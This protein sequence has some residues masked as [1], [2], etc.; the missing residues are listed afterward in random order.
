MADEDR[1]AEVEK[2]DSFHSTDSGLHTLEELNGA[3]E[4]G[5]LDLEPRNAEQE[6]GESEDDGPDL[7][8]LMVDKG[9]C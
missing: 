4:H 2:E 6:D 8:S 5:T 7:A 9:A 1:E 3:L